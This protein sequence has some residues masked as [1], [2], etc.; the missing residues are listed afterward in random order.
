[1]SNKDPNRIAAIEK[2]I[3]EKYGKSTVENPRSKWNQKDGS[4]M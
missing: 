4:M 2:A 1:M 3:A